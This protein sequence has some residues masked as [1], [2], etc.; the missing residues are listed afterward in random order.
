MPK[1]IYLSRSVLLH[2][3]RGHFFIPK[4]TVFRVFYCIFGIPEKP[5]IQ[6]QNDRI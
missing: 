5:A 3:E 2:A 4:D 6:K 1:G